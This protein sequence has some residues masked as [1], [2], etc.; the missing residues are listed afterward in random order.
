MRIDIK[1]ILFNSDL[2][3]TKYKFFIRYSYLLIDLS[4]EIIKLT[5]TN[6]KF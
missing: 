4:V 6:K 3:G 1:K 2:Q 5:N